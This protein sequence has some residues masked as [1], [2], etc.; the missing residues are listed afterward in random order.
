MSLNLY[1]MQSGGC[2]GDTMSFL[3][4]ESPDVPTLMRTLNV[5]LLWHPSLSNLSPRQQAQL[6]EELSAGARALDILVL[7]GA[8]IRGPSGTGMYDARGGRPRKDLIVALAKQAAYV[9]ALGTCAAF[10]G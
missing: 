4:A 8:V 10:G 5:D 9:V 2:G 6:V 7:E 1:W 3:S